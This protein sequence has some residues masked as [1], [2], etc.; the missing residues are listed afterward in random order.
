MKLVFSS[1][2]GQDYFEI[3]QYLDDNFGIEKAVTFEKQ[4][5]E[6]LTLI[7]QQ[8]QAFGFFFDTDYRKCL[9][10]PYITMI[11]TVTTKEIRVHTFWFN[12]ANPDRI[13]QS[14]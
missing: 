14:L 10:N 8:L 1:R 12:R 9:I 2:A 6:K 11:Y 3:I 5:K 7:K 4:L 13:K